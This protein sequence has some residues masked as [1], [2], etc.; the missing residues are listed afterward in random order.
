MNYTCSH[1]KLPQPYTV[2]GKERLPVDERGRLYWHIANWGTDMDRYHQIGILNEVFQEWNR[3]FIPWEFMPTSDFESSQW[4]IYWVKNNI[5]TMPDGS[6]WDT[7]KEGLFDFK[8]NKDTL[9]VEYA[10]PNLLCLINDDHDYSLEAPG[11]NAFELKSV[12]KHELGHGFRLGHTDPA[13]VEREK[14]KG[15]IP[16]MGAYYEPGATITDDEIQAIENLHG[17]HLREFASHPTIARVKRLFSDQQPAPLRKK[18]GCLS[19]LLGG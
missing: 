17:D 11:P 13:A 14:S 7:K 15:K 9:A 6:K 1:S 12:L 19:K 10:S 3:Y 8:K 18:K 5:V 4:K 16:I 2:F